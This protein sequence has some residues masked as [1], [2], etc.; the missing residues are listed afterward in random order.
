MEIFESVLIMGRCLSVERI[1]E[2]L[3]QSKNGQKMVGPDLRFFDFLA[4]SISS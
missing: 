4:C 1:I 2:Y 3:Q